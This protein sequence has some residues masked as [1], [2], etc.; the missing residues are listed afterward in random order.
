[1]G[2]EELE[3]EVGVGDGALVYQVD[4]GDADTSR[5]E[6][7]HGLGKTRVGPRVR[8]AIDKLSPSGEPKWMEGHPGSAKLLTCRWH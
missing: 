6:A 4:G 3:D 7:L 1:M 8:A 2:W 5:L